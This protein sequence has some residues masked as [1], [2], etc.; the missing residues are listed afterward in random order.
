MRG[1]LTDIARAFAGS[2]G[3]FAGAESDVEATRTLATRDAQRVLIA[4][5]VGVLG[6]GTYL[7]QLSVPIYL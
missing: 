7:W 2:R 5:A 4:V 3:E 1:A 6:L